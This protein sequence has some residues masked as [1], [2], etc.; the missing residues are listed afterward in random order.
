MAEDYAEPVGLAE[1]QRVLDK[2]RRDLGLADEFARL[3][4]RCI[5][6]AV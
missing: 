1:V 4:R 2:V 5:V 3:L 6:G